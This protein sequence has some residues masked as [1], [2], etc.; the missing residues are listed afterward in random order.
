M[1]DLKNIESFFPATLRPFKRNILREYLQY[2][3]LEIIFDSPYGNALSF[4]GGTAIQIVH[5]NTRFSEDLDFDN[6]SLKSEDFEKLTDEIVRGLKLIGLKAETK[7]SLRDVF[8][9]Y[10]RFPDVLMDLGLT[11]HKEENVMIQ[12]DTQPQRFS[13]QPEQVILNK[14]DVFLRI[15]VVPVDILLAQKFYAAINRQRT[16]GR[17]FFDIVYL[18]GK[19]KPNYAYL[20]AKIGIKDDG[21]LKAKLLE[22]CERLDFKQLASDVEPFLFVPGDVKKVVLFRE[23]VESSLFT[24][25]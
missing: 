8:R 17:D 14:F 10:I 20:Q 19:T 2:K 1:L 18:S 15:N 3:I 21:E 23:F 16:M 7:T 11:R 6:L 25:G 4:M 13:Y 22:H 9:S 24:K 12:V 5:G